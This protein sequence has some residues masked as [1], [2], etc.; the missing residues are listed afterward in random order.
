MGHSHRGADGD[1]QCRMLLSPRLSSTPTPGGAPG[2]C[3]LLS[4]PLAPQT[5]MIPGSPGS[6]ELDSGFNRLRKRKLSFRRRTEKGT[7]RA[8][9]GWKTGSLV[10]RGEFRGAAMTQGLSPSPHDPH[11]RGHRRGAAERAE[12]AAA[13]QELPGTGGAAGAGRVG[14]LP[15]QLALQLA[16]QR[17][18]RAP[19]AHPGGGRALPF[20]QPPP[21]G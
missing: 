8:W 2:I 17:R 7:G 14:P 19:R 5:N 3:P 18:G 6:D 20:P 11:R 1:E 16:L 21:G 10:G 9:G 4:R 13:G 15:L 12:G